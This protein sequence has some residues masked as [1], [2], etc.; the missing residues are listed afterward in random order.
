ME[1]N[2][3]NEYRNLLY[4]HLTLPEHEQDIGLLALYIAGEHDKSL[5]VGHQ[6]YYLSSLSE[7]VQKEITSGSDQYHLFRSISNLLFEEI[8]FSGNTDDYYNPN[9]SFLHQVFRTRRGIPITLSI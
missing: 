9:N 8:G 3:S 7:Q 4:N 5:D 6:N 1:E 2:I